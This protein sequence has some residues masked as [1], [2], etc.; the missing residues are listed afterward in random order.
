[1]TSDEELT[2][3]F[4]KKGYRLRASNVEEKDLIGKLNELEAGSVTLRFEVDPKEYWKIRKGIES[5]LNGDGKF[6]LF[7]TGTYLILEPI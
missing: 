3:S 5:Q 1:M 2:S 7:K 4:L 6:Q